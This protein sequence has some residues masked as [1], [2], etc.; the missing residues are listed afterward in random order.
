SARE[1][2]SCC[3]VTSVGI[4]KVLSFSPISDAILSNLSLLLAAST[5]LAPALVSSFAIAVPIPLLAPVTMA[6]LSVNCF[7]IIIGLLVQA[8]SLIVSKL[9]YSL[10]N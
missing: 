5:T 2:I 7:D 1:S 8:Y 4:H 9:L 3:L 6:V 10:F